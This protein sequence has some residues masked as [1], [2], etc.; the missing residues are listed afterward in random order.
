MG[1]GGGGQSGHSGHSNFSLG[2]S[3]IV[4]KFNNFRIPKKNIGNELTLKTT[5]TSTMKT[6]YV[7]ESGVDINIFMYKSKPLS[8][9][10]SW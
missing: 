6:F 1:K 10:T 5:T 8:F 2:V 7:I 9:L 3:I 4:A